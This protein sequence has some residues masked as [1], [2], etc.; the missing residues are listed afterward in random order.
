MN[1]Y[2]ENKSSDDDYKYELNS[3]ITYDLKQ[4][5]YITYFKYN[6]KFIKMTKENTNLIDIDSIDIIKNPVLL[7]YEKI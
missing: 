4:E 1:N 7:F 5:E 3:F 2:I 6:N